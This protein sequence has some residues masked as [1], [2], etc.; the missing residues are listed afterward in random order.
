VS[1]LT[2]VSMIAYNGAPAPQRYAFGYVNFSGN[3]MLSG[4]TVPHPNDATQTASAT[5]NYGTDGRVTSEVDGN[6][7][8][9][10]FTYNPSS[11]LVQTLNTSNVVETQYTALYDSQG[12]D[13]GTVDAIGNQT[14]AISYGDSNNPDKPT[15]VTDAASRTTNIAYEPN[16]YGNVSTITS[17]RGV[18]THYAY[19][20]S[21]WP[22]GLLHQSYESVGSG[23]ALVN[24]PPTTLWYLSG[25]ERA[26]LVSEIDSPHPMVSSTWAGATTVASY[27][28]YN[29]FGDVTS[30]TVP[31]HNGYS[32]LST[33]L[34]YTTDGTN[35]SQNVARGQVVSVTDPTGAVSSFRYD[36]RGNQYGVRDALNHVS[37]ATYDLADNVTSQTLPPTGQTGSG[38]SYVTLAYNYLGGMLKTTNSYDESGSG[39]PFRSVTTNYDAEGRTLSV[40]GATEPV[41][42][43]YTSFDAPKTLSDG[44]GHTTT[45]SYNSRG[46]LT[47]IVRPLGN[48]ASGLDVVKLMNYAPD[49]QLLSE[50]DGRGLTTNIAHNDPDGE[51]SQVTLPDET[52]TLSRDAWGRLTGR[53]DASGGQTYAYSD[54]DA[55]LSTTTNYTG[56]PSLTL[57]N[58]YE[59]DG[60][61]SSLS[62]PTGSPTAAINLSYGFDGRGSLT[63][64]NDNA[65]NL[66][67]QW[68]YDAGAR[69]SGASAANGWAKSYT[70]NALDQVLAL[71]Q[72]K[73]GVGSLNFGHPSD[74]NQQLR[75]DGQGNMTR[76]TATTSG[77]VPS[78]VAGIT[79][80]GYDGNDRLNSENS[81]RFSSYA[82]SYTLDAAYNRTASTGVNGSSASWSNLYSGNANNQ[83]TGV[84]TTQSGVTTNV[85]YTYDGEGNRSSVTANGTTTNYVYDSQQRL[86]SVTQ[87][88]GGAT[89]TILTCGYRADGLRAW[90]QNAQGRTYFLYDGARLVGEFDTNGVMQASQAWGAEGLMYRQTASGA[91]AG[92]R[93]YSWDVR[94]NV[95]ATTD[96]TGAVL[97]TPSSDGFSSSGG[98]EPCATFGGQ[99]GGYRDN[100]TGLVLFGYRY[101]D[102]GLGSWLTRDPIREEGGINLYS[103]VQGNPPNSV[104]PSGLVP[105]RPP[106]PNNLFPR[107]PAGWRVT[108]DYPSA[109]AHGDHLHFENTRWPNWKVSIGADGNPINEQGW[110]RWNRLSGAERKS[111]R[112]FLKDNA[113]EIES[114]QQKLSEWVAARRGVALGA[115]EAGGVLGKA[116]EV[117]EGAGK[118]L[119]KLGKAAGV[120]GEVLSPF[121]GP[122]VL[123]HPYSYR[124]PKHPACSAK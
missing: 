24:H 16:G 83:V 15:R 4:I 105:D 61:R 31:G 40:G 107:D 70:Y 64:L 23:G 63:Q 118:A 45:Y 65:Q 119:G 37:T 14:A 94:G 34:N 122:F 46:L 72:N 26:G 49:G 71:T 56:L 54:A 97:N 17:P 42:Y 82:R 36:A 10:A 27:L 69:L 50:T 108:Q 47:Q 115:E 22:F 123:P 79:S 120:V 43:T 87:T 77:T 114:A 32:S 18:T 48:A 121:L 104:D 30:V 74:P 89:S 59:A 124:A 35:Y 75:Y 11:T 96:A 9:T 44:S 102:G 88:T 117:L 80:Y 92:T 116:G 19:D 58:Q 91:S 67:S 95:A 28:T 66:V 81:S 78:S 90:K 84:A 62:G 13:T 68:S 52:I 8:T 112:R 29:A 106:I 38:A 20:Y 33:T 98:V 12:R 110:A 41:S 109:A 101:Y 111:A 60:T 2:G 76:E 86:T 100:E 93:F 57:A 1:T 113:A 39:T 6:G 55:L 85:G 73:A 25:Y 99:V 5:I 53:S 7:N 21:V 3:P 51:V 103:Y